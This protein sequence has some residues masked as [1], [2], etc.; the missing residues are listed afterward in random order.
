MRPLMNFLCAPQPQK[1]AETLFNL[2]AS[3]GLTLF[4][5]L[6][7]GLTLGLM[8]LDHVDLEVRSVAVANTAKA[9]AKA[10][11]RSIPSTGS[12][13]QRNTNREETSCKNST[14]E[15]LGPAFIS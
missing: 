6:M 14:S 7:S 12:Q 3:V 4:A 2:L 10:S 13:A 5:G 15:L 9:S 1:E 11:A 8:S